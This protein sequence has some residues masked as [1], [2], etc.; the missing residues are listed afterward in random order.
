MKIKEYKHKGF[1]IAFYKKPYEEQYS[2]VVKEQPDKE[3]EIA[4]FLRASRF[5]KGQLDNA[6]E[7]ILKYLV[8]SSGFKSKVDV[9]EE[10]GTK[11]DKA[12]LLVIKQRQEK[13][14]DNTVSELNYLVQKT[15]G[16]NIK[17]DLVSKS[18]TQHEPIIKVCIELPDGRKFEGYGTNQKYA[19]KV[20]AG[21]ALDALVKFLEGEEK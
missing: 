9:K 21:E 13:V 2:F 8:D 19:R 6:A 16:K 3:V 17:C 11:F 4:S 14:E 12:F 1:T 18:G 20:A 15:F 7:I 5:E 10:E